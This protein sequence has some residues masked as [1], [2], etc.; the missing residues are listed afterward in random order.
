[1]KTILI[2]LMIGLAG[3]CATQQP[4]PTIDESWRARANWQISFKPQ[5]VALRQRPIQMPKAFLTEKDVIKSQVLQYGYITGWDYVISGCG[6]T[7][8]GSPEI[9]MQDRELSDA[10][11]RGYR[12]GMSNA[13]D[14]VKDYYQKMKD[15]QQPA[16]PY[17]EPAARSPQ[18]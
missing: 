4:S 12:I 1:M 11:M 10:Y 6:G 2:I 16:P 8:A 9:I 14:L 7:L 17:S 15:S 5:Y 3:G 13:V 18:R